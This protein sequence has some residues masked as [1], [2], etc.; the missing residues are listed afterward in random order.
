MI[1]ELGRVVEETKY[2]GGFTFDHSGPAALRL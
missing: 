1:V 2:Q